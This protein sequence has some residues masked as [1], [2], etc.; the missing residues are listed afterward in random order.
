NHNGQIW[1]SKPDVHIGRLA[2]ND[3]ALDDPYASRNHCVIH[4]TAEGYVLQDSGSGNGTYLDGRPISGPVLLKPGQ[5]IT[6]G[7]TTMEV[8]QIQIQPDGTAI[9]VAAVQ[10]AEP[11]AAPAVT[12]AIPVPVAPPNVST[13]PV[14]PEAQ[15]AVTPF[16]TPAKK[17]RRIRGWWARNR[18]K[19]WWRFLLVGLAAYILATISLSV[20][21]NPHAVP[22][23]LILGAGLVPF[24]FVRYCW[25]EGAF[26]DMP[27]T[28]LVPVFLYG[29]IAGLLLAGVLEQYLVF[30][31]TLTGA[32]T[33]GLIEEGSK[34]GVAVFASRKM[35]LRS[36]FD[37]LVLGAA[38]GMGFAALETAGYGFY[39]FLVGFRH[40]GFE[41]GVAGM[42]GELIVRMLLA[43]FGHGTWTA[44][45]CAA[46]WRER[47]NKLIRFNGSTLFAFGIAVFL[48]AMWD[49]ITLIAIIPVA[50]IGIFILRFFLRESIERQ[51]LGP[52]APPPAPLPK[53][54]WAYTRGAFRLGPKYA[55]G[56]IDPPQHWSTLDDADSGSGPI[57]LMAQAAIRCLE[58]GAGCPAISRFCWNCGDQLSHP[59]AAPAT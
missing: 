54:L 41:G 18:S 51:R 42:T 5:R 47:G 27:I 49:W 26:A 11:G 29:A 45:T 55:P 56:R 52:N 6:V 9:P 22:L 57:D 44:I 35:R 50:V 58:C 3:V 33:V 36:E 12:D 8:V 13:T 28:A 38:A 1:L 4:W 2:S 32:L 46:I 14:A 10:P 40:S 43:A 59:G 16:P 17:R 37:G 53:A 24:V 21:P 30:S 23:V 19:R 31:L 25:E 48:H 15:A 34:A 39:A 20:I 7:K